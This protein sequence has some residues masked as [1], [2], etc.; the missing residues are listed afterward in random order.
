MHLAQA[1]S[2]HETGNQIEATL[3]ILIGLIFFIRQSIRKPVGRVSHFGLSIAF[4]LFGISDIVE[5]QTG[6]WWD[7]WWLFTW[8]GVC[9]VYFLVQFMR[10]RKDRAL[11]TAA[12]PKSR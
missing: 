4:I 5:I 7:P 11:N 12:E 3:W 1:D 10:Y 9:V 6:A 2:L 8:K